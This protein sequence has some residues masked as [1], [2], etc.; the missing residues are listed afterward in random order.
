MK[1]RLKGLLL[2][3]IIGVMIATTSVIASNGTI[4]KILNY[5]NIKITMNGQE[6]K[7]TD[8][9]GNYV[10]PFII[11]GTTYLPVRGIAN[12]LGLY[13]DW[14]SKTNTVKL[15]ETP[16]ESK[17][18]D[19]TEVEKFVA[20]YGEEFISAF[21]SGFIQSGLTGKTVITG[22]GNDIIVE[23]RIDNVDGVTDEVKAM[24]QAE[25]D[26]QEAELKAQFDGIEEELPSLEKM[27][28]NICEQDGDLLA[29]IE[30]EF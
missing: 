23:L 14:D 1:E 30:L 16:F 8:A 5:N 21:E 28:F 11:D 26:S 3:I 22:R 12:A 15:S 13:V 4:Q 6:V 24:L 18:E 7:P 29:I 27:I 20:E 25:Y 10:E 9:N 19:M 2:G 17:T